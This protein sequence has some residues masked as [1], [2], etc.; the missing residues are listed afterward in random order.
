MTQFMKHVTS[1]VVKNYAPPTPL[2]LPR[3]ITLE[4]D[5]GS[6]FRM[7]EV[8][9]VKVTVISEM[10][11]HPAMRREEAECMMVDKL[12]DFVYQDVFAACNDIIELAYASG[13]MK[14]V[15]RVDNLKRL[16]REKR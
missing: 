15:D 2:G 6:V 10:K 4:V 14:T 7:G 16:L 1:E 9:A 8:I 12:A 5:C 11:V 3:D 13:C